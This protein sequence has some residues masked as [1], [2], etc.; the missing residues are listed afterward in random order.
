MRMVLRKVVS[1]FALAAAS[2]FGVA[3]ANAKAFYISGTS[4][5]STSAGTSCS[6]ALSV[7]WFNN[8]SSWGYASHQISPGTTVFLCGAFNGHPGQQLLGVQG[9]G[10]AGNPITIKFLPGAVLSAPYWSGSGAI[11]MQSRSYIVVDGGSNG[12]IQNTANGTGRA[13]RQQSV[14]IHARSC[15]HCTVQNLTIQ[16]LYV[17]TSATDLAATHTVNCVSWHLANNLTINNITCH[18]ASWAI[19]GD[20]NN[21]TLS[22]SNIYHVDHG[23]ASGAYGKAGGYSIHNNHFH[24]FANWDSPTNTYHHDGI[25]LWGQ[26]GGT[27]TGGAIYNN[28]FD[29]DF[30][31]NITAHVFLQDSVQ[32]VSV[33]NNIAVAPTYRTINSIWITATS[34]SMPGGPAIG[35]SANN[36][37]INAGGHR[38][39]CAIYADNQL[40]FTAV[41]NILGGGVSDVSIQRGTTLTSAG[42]N[43]NVY[44]DLLAEFGDRN[45]FSFKGQYF[46]SLSQWRAACRCD[47]ASKL[48]LGTQTTAFSSVVGGTGPTVAGAAVTNAA[49]VTGVD[50]VASSDAVNLSVISAPTTTDPE[51]ALLYTV[52]E[53]NG[54][55]LSDLAVGDLA[56]LA[57][58]MNG[59]PRP[60]AGPW[61]V[62]PF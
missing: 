36:N 41:N 10:T 51:F 21:F 19:A 43:Y 7:G 37:S 22:N 40:Q 42:V 11:N 38:S 49:A 52:G 20:G 30:G 6:N 34:T 45:A 26:N 9:S 47:Y 2:L 56:P 55:N 18:D 33:Y 24:D 58:G 48:I 32:H 12:I 25:H 3:S 15:D 50:A 31:V 44:R 28:T 13:Y 35:N 16:N 59:A 53:G 5:T 1:V 61:N 29:G 27:I 62:G 4:S 23:V 46:F 57:V 17:R 8:S 54:L 60:T 39:G 14:A